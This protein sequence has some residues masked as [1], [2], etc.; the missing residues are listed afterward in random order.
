MDSEELYE[1]LKTYFPNNVD[2]MRHLN[3]NACWE[4]IIT[5]NSTY[6]ENFILR[7]FLYKKNKKKLEVTKNNPNI[8]PDLIL[9]FTERAILNLIKGNPDAEEYYSR[10]R[11][12]MNNPKPG[13]EVDYKVN[14]PRLKLWQMGYRK[15]QSDFKFYE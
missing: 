12:I 11:E 15:W 8:Q 6:E 13:T 5:N 3:V 14:K 2:L 7:Y 9:Y 10:Y 4:Y 1:K